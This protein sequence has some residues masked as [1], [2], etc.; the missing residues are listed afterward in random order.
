MKRLITSVLIAILIGLNAW[1]SITFAQMTEITAETTTE[2]TTTPIKKK[3]KHKKRCY[4]Y[5]SLYWLKK[6]LPIY[7]IVGGV[8]FI[9]I[10]E[11]KEKGYL[12]TITKQYRIIDNYEDQLGLKCLNQQERQKA[13]QEYEE[14]IARH[15]RRKGYQ[16]TYNGIK[17]GFDDEGI[18]LICRKAGEKTLLVQ[19]KNWSDDKIIH[20]NYIFELA[21]AA[22]YYEDRE[23]DE[24]QVAFYAT[25]PLSNKAKIV[26]VALGITAH[27][28]FKI[29][30]KD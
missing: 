30:G 18:D 24:V 29:L 23:K 5:D 25:C 15:L 21:G 6:W 11:K 12:K 16:I 26:A 4:P 27:E 14:Y 17:K 13:G 20:E 22:R 7:V 1:P 2:K 8:L 3:Y 9:Y 28:N 10:C 19:C